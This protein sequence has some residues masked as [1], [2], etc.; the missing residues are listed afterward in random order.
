MSNLK[1]IMLIQEN[2]MH[3][4][5][6]VNAQEEAGINVFY[7]PDLDREVFSVF[8]HNRLPFRTLKDW[9]FDSFRA[10]RNFAASFFK[11]E[12]EVLSWDLKAKR[13][14]AEKDGSCGT[15]KIKKS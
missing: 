2:E 15:C 13:P 4:T 6:F 14:C 3:R 5:I 1:E 8:I 7:D 12:W 9:K 11:S 10:A